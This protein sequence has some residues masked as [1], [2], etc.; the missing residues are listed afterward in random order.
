MLRLVMYEYGS[1][2]A[3]LPGC[4]FV[5]IVRV[6]IFYL[7]NAHTGVGI[8][9]YFETAILIAGIKISGC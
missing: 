1:S 4:K 3:P 9:H 6:E 8:A 7:N 5:V 2:I